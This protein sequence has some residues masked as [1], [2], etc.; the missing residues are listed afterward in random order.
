MET[1]VCIGMYYQNMSIQKN[2]P[3]NIACAR[4]IRKM[5]YVISEENN[6]ILRLKGMFSSLSNLEFHLPW[7]L[8]TSE[9]YI[10][11]LFR[12]S[13]NKAKTVNIMHYESL[14]KKT[15]LLDWIPLKLVSITIN[16]NKI[17]ENPM[18]HSFNRLS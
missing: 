15:Y 7:C 16:E 18:A 12:C 2:Y 14:I 8:W 17:P 9:N 10:F 1:T 11:F 6:P 3:A 4:L 13:T 5:G